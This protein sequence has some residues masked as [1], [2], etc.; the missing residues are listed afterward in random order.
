MPLAESNPKQAEQPQCQDCNSVTHTTQACPFRKSDKPPA[1]AVANLTS[2]ARI[3]GI[4][5]QPA[6]QDER[7]C[8]RF[9]NQDRENATAIGKAGLQALKEIIQEV[10]VSVSAGS[11]KAEG[12]GSYRAQEGPRE[13]TTR[14][15]RHQER[16]EPAWDVNDPL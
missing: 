4:N 9:I 10:V 8:S 2:A 7:W 15:G 11:R 5:D 14:V 12:R 6:S 13:I 16:E 1:S 3:F